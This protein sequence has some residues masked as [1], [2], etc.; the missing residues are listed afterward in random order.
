MCGSFPGRYPDVYHGS[1]GFEGLQY[2]ATPG[3]VGCETGVWGL[4]YLQTRKVT[5]GF[6]I[7]NWCSFWWSWQSCN[8]FWVFNYSSRRDRNGF[9][10]K[11]GDLASPIANAGAIDII[12]VV[13][14]MRKQYI[15]MIASISEGTS[16]ECI[17]CTHPLCPALPLS[18]NAS[19]RIHEIYNTVAV[20]W[21]I[22]FRDH[23]DSLLCDHPAQECCRVG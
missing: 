6:F 12:V 8:T 16:V 21:Y 20:H 3:S 1:F 19:P 9:D 7:P 23:L 5:L 14:T 13:S 4:V 10:P 15:A 22:L 17:I 11:R 18:N 2:Q